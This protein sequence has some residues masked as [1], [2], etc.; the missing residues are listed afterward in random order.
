MVRQQQQS[1]TLAAA[2]IVALLSISTTTNAFSISPSLA[3]THGC[4]SPM[5]MTTTILQMAQK[6]TPTRRTRRDDSFDREEEE[7]GED[8]MILDFSEAQAKIRDDENKRRVEEGLTVGLT[9]EDEEEFNAKKN[10]YEDMRSKIRARASE[11]GF[12]KS[13]ATKKAI[14]EATQRAMAGQSNATP[15]QM[16]D[17]SGFAEKFTDDGTDELTEEEQMEI[18]KIA[19]MPLFEQ[20]QEELANTRFPTPLAIFQ[21]ACVMALIFA[22]SATLILKGDATIRDFYMGLGFIPRPDEVYDF[23]DLDLPDGFLE[24]QDLEGNIG[25]AVQKVTESFVPPTLD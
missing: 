14:E 19:N 4:R 13:V 15:D 24:Q 2:V 22:V 17:L 10:D 9:K 8:E 6:M 5:T 12:E 7:E 3:T 18:D 21:T 20:V 25:D 16:L 1:T 11:E 23:S